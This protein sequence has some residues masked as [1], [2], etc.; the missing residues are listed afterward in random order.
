ME[1]L[2]GPPDTPGATSPGLPVAALSWD[3]GTAWT[4]LLLQRELPCDVRGARAVD[5]EGAAR[6][7]LGALHARM[8]D[9][10]RIAAGREIF[11]PNLSVG[12]GLSEVRC[13]G[14]VDVGDHPVVD[15][16]ADG[17]DASSIEHH[18]C[19]RRPDVEG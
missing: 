7:L 15:V 19:G 18:R 9:A 16:A 11:Q 5:G 17:R 13:L 4:K 14:D 3:R 1:P 12:P 10:H 2:S 6:R 8:P